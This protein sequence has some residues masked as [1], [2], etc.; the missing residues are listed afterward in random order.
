[1]T[2]CRENQAERSKGDAMNLGFK[3]I[4]CET[5]I[6]LLKKGDMGIIKLD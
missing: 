3:L 2:D 5:Q 1:M 4:R 6:N